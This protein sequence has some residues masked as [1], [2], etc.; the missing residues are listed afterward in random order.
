MFKNILGIG[1]FGALAYFFFQQKKRLVEYLRVNFKDIAIDSKATNISQ[2]VFNL[3]L[4]L[5]NPTSGTVIINEIVGV[6]EYQDQRLASFNSTD[7]FTITARTSKDVIIKVKLTTFGLVG[8]LIK[9]I[10]SDEPIIF[11]IKGY[12]GTNFGKID[13]EEEQAV[14][15][16]FEALKDIFKLS[17]GK[18][19]R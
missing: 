18:R 9:I 5:D 17:P 10:G 13:Y 11:N 15:A 12:I 14:N 7:N 6:I 16:D 4:N 2:I 19:Y 3:K 8:T 1:V